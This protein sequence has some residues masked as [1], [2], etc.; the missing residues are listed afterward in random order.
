VGSRRDRNE[1]SRIL[2]KYHQSPEVVQSKAKGAYE[3]Q[4]AGLTKDRKATKTRM[5]DPDSLLVYELMKA[6]GNEQAHHKAPLLTL[7]ILYKGLNDSESTELTEY[8]NQFHS[9]GNAL[10]NLINM[11]AETHQGGIHSIA[12]AWNYEKDNKLVSKGWVRD[13]EDASELPLAY[14]KHIGEQYMKQAVADMEN[15][16]N[17]LLTNHPSMLEKIDLSKVR[18]AQDLK[19]R[20]SSTPQVEDLVTVDRGARKLTSDKSIMES[21]SR[22][23]G[24]NPEAA[25]ALE[26]ASGKRTDSP[27]DSKERALVINSGGGNVT[28]GEGVLRSNGNGKHKNGNG[29]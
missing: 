18:A 29:H 7:D 26:I 1:E 8:L 15:D 4:L 10:L 19:D 25:R 12:K 6:R 5:A 17:D 28:I 27:G 24:T 9:T 3:S 13:L 11:P 2:A 20:M 16:I 21:P 22:M 23:A 14:R